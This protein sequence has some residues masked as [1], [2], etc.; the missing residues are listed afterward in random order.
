MYVIKWACDSFEGASDHLGKKVFKMGAGTKGATLDAIASSLPELF[1]TAFLL[2]LYH[3][4]DGFAAGIATCAGSAVFNAAVIPAICII[5]VTVK[6]VDGNIIEKI[7]I[8]KRVILRDGFFFLLAEVALI[9]FLGTTELAWWVGGALIAIYLVYFGVLSRSFGTMEHE[10]EE[11]ED[12]EEELGFFGNLITL[13]YNGLLFKGKDFTTGSA[14][15]VFALSTASIGAAC[16][17]LA[18]AVIGSADAL[19]VPA[20]F[21]AVILGAAATSVPDTFISYKSAMKGDYDD[22]V[23]NAVGS[24][25]FD[26]C[27]ALGLPLL[28]YGLVYG[29]VSLEGASGGASNVQELRIALIV[30]SLFILAF[31]LFNKQETND[32]GDSVLMIG[33]TRGWLLGSLYVVWTVYIVGR[34]M[35]W[36]WLS[37]LIDT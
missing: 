31:F 30:I 4:H 24:N 28:A 18:E 10:D 25:I 9:F 19:G 23:A 3:D 29:T 20:Y 32:D 11:D 14:W 1:T 16:Y 13:N 26:I 12:E 5:A 22:A 15:T 6:G 36:Q 2:F 8:Q 35:E 34:A 17:F 33:Q 27:V 37:N 21:T 7:G